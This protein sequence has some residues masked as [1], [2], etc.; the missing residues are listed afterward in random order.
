MT[1]PSEYDRNNQIMSFTSL[2]S[3]QVEEGRLPNK[4]DIKKKNTVTKI[5]LH[6]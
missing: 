5:K 2:V 4:K 6:T 3:L 1:K